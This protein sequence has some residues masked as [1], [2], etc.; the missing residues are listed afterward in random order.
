[1]LFLEAK[2]IFIISFPLNVKTFKF[3]EIPFKSKQ[4]CCFVLLIYRWG[5]L[6]QYL[7]LRE[8]ILG[9]FS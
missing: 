8:L 4:G 2:L 1:M 5:I 9:H 7:N 6:R 3:Y